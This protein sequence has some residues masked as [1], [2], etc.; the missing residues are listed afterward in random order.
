MIIFSQTSHIFIT[1]LINN[2]NLSKTRFT[3]GIQLVPSVHH[4]YKVSIVFPDTEIYFII[5]SFVMQLIV[6]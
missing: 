1:E 6:I 3:I 2:Q 4:R 5:V